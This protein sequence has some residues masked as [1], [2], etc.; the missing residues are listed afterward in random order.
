MLKVYCETPGCGK[1]VKSIST[2]SFKKF[3]EGSQLITGSD[4][5][6]EIEYIGNPQ[7]YFLNPLCKDMEGSQRSLG[8]WF[9]M[10]EVALL[11]GLKVRSVLI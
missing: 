6:K 11:C 7:A 8:C 9:T 10:M 3:L 2:T 1:P 4:S 5:N